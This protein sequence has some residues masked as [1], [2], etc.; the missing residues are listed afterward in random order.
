MSKSLTGR[1]VK[2]FFRQ[3]ESFYRFLEEREDL[4]CWGIGVVR[5][6]SL[7]GEELGDVVD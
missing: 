6:K 3:R 2:D 1:G 4:V 5:F 7:R